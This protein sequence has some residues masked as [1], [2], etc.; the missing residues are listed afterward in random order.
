M[1]SETSLQHPSKAQVS[2]MRVLM[3]LLF[4]PHSGVPQSIGGPPTLHAASVAGLGAQGLSMRFGGASGD[5]PALIPGLSLADNSLEEALR[6]QIEM[7]RQVGLRRVYATH[8]LARPASV[9][10]SVLV[11][12]R[13]KELSNRLRRLC[14][15]S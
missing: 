15:A 8:S 13:L 3:L 7:Q 1:F 6:V 10:G 11:I 4:P 12:A 9:H 5:P 2:G 14:A